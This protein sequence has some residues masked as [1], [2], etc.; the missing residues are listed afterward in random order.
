MMKISWGTNDPIWKSERKKNHFFCSLQ[1]EGWWCRIKAFSDM[2]L[3]M[4][5]WS[6]ISLNILSISVICHISV[7]HS[8]NVTL[9]RNIME[10]TCVLNV[11][12]V[13]I[14]P[15]TLFQSPDWVINVP[16]IKHHMHLGTTRYS[17]ARTQAEWKSAILFI[18]ST[19]FECGSCIQC[20]M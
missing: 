2:F 4:M 7:S 10:F 13:L 16:L 8:V 17:S 5:R 19:L 3:N 11:N 6:W 15:L 14:S 9:Q 1:C 18:S 20:S 12:W